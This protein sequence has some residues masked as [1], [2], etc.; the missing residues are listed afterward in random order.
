MEVPSRIEQYKHELLTS[1]LFGLSVVVFVAFLLVFFFVELRE[2]RSGLFVVSFITTVIIASMVLILGILTIIPHFS[3]YVG[4]TLIVFSA[5]II[6]AKLVQ[7]MGGKVGIFTFI[8][9]F[10]GF[11]SFFYGYELVKKFRSPL[12]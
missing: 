11:V 4:K 9:I 7:I 10:I 8:E 3:Y 2:L 12:D 6:L 1:H 5:L